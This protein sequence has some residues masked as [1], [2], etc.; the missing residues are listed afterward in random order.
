MW[1]CGTV[2]NM[3]RFAALLL[4]PAIKLETNRSGVF[5]QVSGVPKPNGIMHA[6]EIASMALCLLENIRVHKVEHRP[7]LKLKLRIGIHT[8][9]GRTNGRVG[10]SGV[11]EGVRTKVSAKLDD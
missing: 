5:R 6:G 7:D 1:L 8:G 11:Q 3:Q 2:N 4:Q 10:V 9:T